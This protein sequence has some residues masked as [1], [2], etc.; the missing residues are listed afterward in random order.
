MP[1]IAASLARWI[2]S[3][4]QAEHL[5][6]LYRFI[7]TGRLTTY[8]RSRQVGD[9]VRLTGAHGSFTCLLYTPD[10]ADE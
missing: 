5:A 4:R 10:A 2:C 8:L 6:I 7:P 9:A 1:V 3:A